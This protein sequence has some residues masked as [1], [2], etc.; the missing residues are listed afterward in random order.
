MRIS[1]WSSDVCSADLLALFSPPSCARI[2]GSQLRSVSQMSRLAVLL[3]AALVAL[4]AAGPAAAERWHVGP[5]PSDHADQIGRA[6][7]RAR[8]SQYVEIPLRARSLNTK[9]HSHQ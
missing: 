9:T 6:P 3:A 1:D 2:I 7:C 4:P 5:A 8:V